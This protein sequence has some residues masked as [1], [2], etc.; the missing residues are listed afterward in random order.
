MYC[1]CESKENSA[2]Q[3]G[4]LNMPMPR[5]LKRRRPIRLWFLW[6]SDY[7]SFTFSKE[8]KKAEETE[9]KSHF[10]LMRNGCCKECMKA[11]SGSGKACICQVPASV[12]RRK[13]PDSGCIYCGCFGSK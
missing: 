1:A 8:R 3:R 10:E 2:P 9:S 11:F 6:K 13:L 12:R 7:Y 5:L 4:L